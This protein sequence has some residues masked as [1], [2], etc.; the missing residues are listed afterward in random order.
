MSRVNVEWANVARSSYL[1]RQRFR[2]EYPAAISDLRHRLVIV[3]PERF[4]DQRLLLHEVRASEPAETRAFADDF[5]NTILE[6]RAS[7][8]ATAIEFD[9]RIAVERRAPGEPRP[10]PRRWLQSP[11]ALLP[12]RLTRAD[13]RLS[14]VAG[15]LSAGGTGGLELASAVNAWVHGALRYEFATRVSTTAAEALALGGGVCQDYAHV[16]LAVC[17]ALGLPALYVSGHLVGE[18]GTHAWVEVILPDRRG[19]AAWAFDPTHGSRCGLQYVT[20]AVGRD[21]RDVAPT[22]GVYSGPPG[23]RLTAHKRM[24]VTGFVLAPGGSAPSR[25]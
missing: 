3:P 18:G 5:G 17:R 9:A 25:C 10:V 14:E 16:M 2:Y 6:F 4:G 15:R 21:Y 22:S 20:V 12:T 19:A 13:R 1:V 24:D 8:V 11:A 23:G 7:R